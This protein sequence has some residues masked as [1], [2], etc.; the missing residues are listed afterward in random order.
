M[1][2]P[3]WN[4]HGRSILLRSTDAV[5]WSLVS[6]IWRGEGNDE[7]DLGWLPDRRMLATARLEV[8]PD[9]TLGNRD[10]ST[11]LATAAP[12][13]ESWTYH[14][15]RV[16][17]LDGPALFAYDGRIYAVAR[18]QAG[19]RS[20]FTRLGGTFSRKRTSL[21]LVEPERLV[22]LS[23]LPSAGDTSYAGVVLKDGALFASYYTSEIRRDYPWILGMVLPTRIRMTQVPLDRLAGL[24][25]EKAGLKEAA[26]PR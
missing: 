10:A 25:R 24:A 8:T 1:Y 4:H 2:P 22:R 18:Y 26:S 21:F 12:P 9:R 11:L 14:K 16:T 19:P 7:A 17:P 23:D 20:V 5:R 6:E 13:Y 3:S 15:S